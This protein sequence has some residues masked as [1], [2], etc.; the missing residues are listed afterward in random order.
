MNKTQQKNPIMEKIRKNR[1]NKIPIG[2]LKA[3]LHDRMLSIL[4]FKKFRQNDRV[5]WKIKPFSDETGIVGSEIKSF[6]AGGDDKKK[7]L[8]N[9]KIKDIKDLKFISRNWQLSDLLL[10]IKELNPKQLAIINLQEEILYITDLSLYPH[11]KNIHFDLT[12]S[13][14]NQE[15]DVLTKIIEVLQ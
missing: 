10:A 3:T 8:I 1:S 15:E 6:I 9:G 11:T 7:L 12:E 5:S 2:I 13:L 4:P 14:L